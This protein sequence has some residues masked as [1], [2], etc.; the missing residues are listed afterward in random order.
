V[1]SASPEPGAPVD[2]RPT[3]VLR[4]APDFFDRLQ[5]VARILLGPYI[6]GVLLAVPVIFG[7]L[8]YGLA[9]ASAGAG[10]QL[11]GMLGAGAVVAIGVPLTILLPGRGLFMRLIKSAGLLVMAVG[12]AGEARLLWYVMLEP[13]WMTF[14]FHRE[15]DKLSIAGTT[16]SPLYLDGKPAG[17]HLAV[18]VRVKHRVTMDTYGRLAFSVL[19]E[20]AIAMTEV[21]DGG[22]TPPLS[23][24]YMPV[25]ITYGGRP[26]ESLPGIGPRGDGRNWPPEGVS[27]PAGVYRV[28]R[29][30]WLWGLRTPYGD[31]KPCR[32]D[33]AMD[34]QR[35]PAMRKTQGH[36]LQVLLGTRMS[37][38]GRLGYRHFQLASKPLQYRY[39]HEQWLSVLP[40][41]PVEA[42]SAVTERKRLAEEAA[43]AARAEQLYAAGST[44]LN[45]KDNPLY[46]EMCAEDLEPLRRR[47]AGGAPRYNLSGM[48]W[49]CAV[50][51]PRPELFALLIPVLYARTEERD[52]YCDTLREMHGQRMLDFLAIVAAE[53]LPLVCPGERSAD[54]RTGISPHDAHG[55]HVWAPPAEETYRW[56]SLLKSQN[57]ALCD[58]TPDGDNLLRTYIV[59]EPAKTIELLLD[60]GCDVQERPKRNPQ[61]RFDEHAPL[62]AAALWML[63]RFDDGK[64]ESAPPPVDPARIPIITKR[65]GDVQT[66]E[67]TEVDPVTG[68]TF[69]DDHGSAAMRNPQLMLYL[70]AHGVRLDAAAHNIPRSW[71]YPG[72]NPSNN[73]EL[74]ERPMLDELSVA[75]LRELIAPVDSLTHQPAVPMSE[76]QNF[77]Q[78]G[79]GTYL[80][81]RSVIECRH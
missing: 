44:M 62:S 59:S 41:L 10:G 23:Q 64:G 34:A 15:M 2:G 71:F 25:S 35:E 24:D 40:S 78:A 80:C 77:S 12:L 28:E 65:I 7:L 43:A 8:A 39:A 18:D 60:A 56:L 17:I 58:N 30:F 19:Q 53:K 33:E 1:P 45:E 75:Q 48:T 76:V 6:V 68:R 54:W 26:L 22:R 66:S 32:T 4:P 20:P 81:R 27:L 11:L 36:L 16:E 70:L 67:L 57:V 14:R 79:L 42:C 55:S 61:P 13:A 21:V 29:D 3:P 63:R 5:R 51:R 74:L 47:L 69:L 50:D 46:R 49:Q 37:L 31:T 52:A 38:N 72:Y 73:N 9:H